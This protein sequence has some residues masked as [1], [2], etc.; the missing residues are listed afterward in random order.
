MSDALVRHAAD[1]PHRPSDDDLPMLTTDAIPGYRVVEVIGL[2]RGNTIR[3]RNVGH[4]IM[5]ALKALVGGEITEYT[6]MMAESREQSLDRMRAEALARGAN[7]IYSVRFSTSMVMASAAE[8]MA[9]GT[10]VRIEPVP[11][12]EA[13]DAG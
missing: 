8:I 10:A 11:Q 9:Y 6:K 3:A 1:L 4:D 5:A 13:G 2:V 7:A 12:P